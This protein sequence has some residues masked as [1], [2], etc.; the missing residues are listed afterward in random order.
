MKNI[1]E[2]DYKLFKWAQKNAQK[3]KCPFG[4]L[5]LNTE[6]PRYRTRIAY[7]YK[8]R[9]TNHKMYWDT[10]YRISRKY[11]EWFEKNLRKT[12]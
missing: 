10:R 8:L 1:R 2:E 7:L 4:Y 12:Y 3:V 9:K 11:V 5:D 6:L